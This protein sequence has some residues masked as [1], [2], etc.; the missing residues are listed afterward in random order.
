[1]ILWGLEALV[2]PKG[3]QP[4]VIVDVVLHKFLFFLAWNAKFGEMD[5]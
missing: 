4:K 1:M 2:I 3:Q 5:L